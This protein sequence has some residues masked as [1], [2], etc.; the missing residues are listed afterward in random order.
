[1]RLWPVWFLVFLTSCSGPRSEPKG[2]EHSCQPL[3]NVKGP[4][5]CGPE[6]EFIALTKECAC[7]RSILME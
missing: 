3:V 5:A 6:H 7:T 4:E 1:M 2:P